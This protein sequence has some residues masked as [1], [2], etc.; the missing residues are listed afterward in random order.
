MA[1]QKPSVITRNYGLIEFAINVD[2]RDDM[3]DGI[4][5][6][7]SHIYWLF[8]DESA[9][10]FSLELHYIQDGKDKHKRF[11]VHAWDNGLKGVKEYLATIG[12]MCFIRAS[13][14]KITAFAIELRFLDKSMQYLTGVTETLHDKVAVHTEDNFDD[15]SGVLVEHHEDI[16]CEMEQLMQLNRT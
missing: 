12:K 7:M 14:K 4:L 16:K 8:D 3:I 1:E 13:K 15:A 6:T 2:S 11:G 5:D 9:I 10:N